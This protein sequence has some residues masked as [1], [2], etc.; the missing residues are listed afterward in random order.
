MKT[1]CCTWCLAP[2]EVKDMFDERKRKMVCSQ[3]CKDA[4][5]LFT[6]HWSDEEINRREHYRILTLGEE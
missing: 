6:L 3:S 5:M 1:V 2:I 4:E